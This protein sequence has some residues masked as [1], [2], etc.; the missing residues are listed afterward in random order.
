[1]C[2]CTL[3]EAV[4][5]SEYILRKLC[6]YSLKLSNRIRSTEYIASLRHPALLRHDSLIIVQN[7]TETREENKK[8]QGA[9]FVDDTP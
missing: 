2:V 5:W 1:M 8:F 4:F 7:M 6:N 9:N 3:N